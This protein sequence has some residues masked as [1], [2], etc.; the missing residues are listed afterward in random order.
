[1]MHN[2]WDKIK[3]TSVHL[4]L[5]T[6]STLK[7]QPCAY[8]VARLVWRYTLFFYSLT[9]IVQYIQG[10]RLGSPGLSPQQGNSGSPQAP[11]LSLSI[12]LKPAFSLFP[13]LE[14]GLLNL[15]LSSCSLHLDARIG[16]GMGRRDRLKRVRK[17]KGERKIK[18]KLRK[19]NKPVPG[20]SYC[21][22]AN[23]HLNGQDQK[24][25]KSL[26]IYWSVYLAPMYRKK[27]NF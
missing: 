19:V 7:P 10:K 11:K 20:D 6:H 1:M 5:A 16:R 21:N 23:F 14:K 4:H 3:S 26:T 9:R 12:D 17:E 8:G 24:V 27:T 13:P 2:T 18:G 15:S 25:H 22:H